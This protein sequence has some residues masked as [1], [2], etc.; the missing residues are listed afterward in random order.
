MD[1]RL[2]FLV[3]QTERYGE[4]LQNADGDNG[5]AG[6][7]VNVNAGGVVGVVERKMTI[8]EALSNSSLGR[9]R[10]NSSTIDY[11]R[12]DKDVSYN[13]SEF[14]GE[15]IIT[16][17][18]DDLSTSCVDEE[19]IDDYY[20]PTEEEL[21]NEAQ[22]EQM[23]YTAL[24]QSFKETS[25]R[26]EVAEEIQKLVQEQDMDLESLIGRLMEEGQA[27]EE[28][29]PAAAAEE[30]KKPLIEVI[31]ETTHAKEDA[32]N[33]SSG[34]DIRNI[35]KRR[36]CF[37]P[38][39]EERTIEPYTD[40]GATALNDGKEEAVVNNATQHKNNLAILN[41]DDHEEEDE[42][43]LK[44]EEL[45][46]ETTIDAEEKLGRD[47]S[48]QEE[49]DLLKQE[50]DMSIEELRAMYA[51]MEE[52]NEGASTS[53]DGNDDVPVAA[54]EYENTSKPAAALS[55]LDE[56][57]QD[58]KDEFH[59]ETEEIDDETTIEV[60][61]KLG[62]D[63][64]YQDEI[65][66]LKM[67]G[68]MSIEE[69]RAMYANM[70]EG[71]NENG[72]DNDD[73]NDNNAPEN[74]HDGNVT[75]LNE[76]A[77]ST[78][79]LDENDEEEKDEF[80]LE[81]EELDDETTIEAEEKLGRDMSYQE[82]IDLL[83][84]EN[85]MSADEL[86]AMYANMDKD[87]SSGDGHDEEG[88]K[89]Q[90]GNDTADS[91]LALL[92][93]DDQEE[94]DEFHLEKEELDDETTIEAE[95]KLGRDMSYQE[96]I[97]LLKQENEMSVE[98]LRAMY[99]NM[100]EG[101]T[102]SEGEESNNQ[103]GDDAEAARMLNSEEAGM[104]LSPRAS[105]KRKHSSA[106]SESDADDDVKTT[107]KAKMDTDEGITEIESLAASDTKAR[108]TMLTRPFLLAS[109][110]KLRAYQHVGLNWL[111]SIQSRRL[112][113]ILADEMGLGKTLQTISMLA[114]L[115]S[116]KGIWGP[117]LIIVP[118]SCLVNWEVE[119]KRFAPGLKVMCYY[120]NAKRRKELRTGWTKPNVHHV[121]ITSYQLAVQDAFAF[122]R[123]KWYYLILDEAHNIKNFESQ[124]WQTLIGF[125]TQRRLLLTGTPLQNNL[126][127]LWSLLHF[128]MPHVFTDRKQFSYWFSN[129]M[130]SIIEGN[131]KRNDDLI[132][133]LHGIIRPFVLRRLKK[134]VETQLP[135]KFEHIVKCQ[136][137]RRQLFLYEEFMARSSTRK[138]MSGG[139]FMGMMSVLMQLRKVCNHPDLFEPRSVTTPF[140]MEPISMSTAAC[141][142]NAVE[143]ESAL[144]RLSPFLRLPLW[145]MG[146]GTPSFQKSTSVD[147]I[148]A[149]QLSD[150]KTTASTI[151]H[152]V[153]NDDLTEPMPHPEMNDGL[154]SLLSRIRAAEKHDRV[155]RAQFISEVNTQR[156]ETLTFPYSDRL[157]QAV[158]LDSSS[159]CDLPLRDELTASQIAATPIELLAMR[160]SQ[161]ERAEDLNEIADK[162][163]FCVPKA[164][165]RK[166]ALFSGNTN[167]PSSATEGTLL[168]KSSTALENYFTPFKKA[169]SRLTMCFP[170][171]K[172]VQ[173]DAGKLQK[174]ATLLRELKRGGHRVLI[175]TQMSKMLDVLEA[176]LNLNGH[177]YLRLDGA[178]DVERRQRLMDR[179][180]NDPKVFCFILS[181]R[182]G[183]LGINL[184]GADTVVFYD[185][186]WNPAMDA[187]AQDR[188]HRIGQTREVHIYRMVTEH[189]IEENILT[190]AKQ[191]R[192][193]DFLVMDEGKF[194][195]TAP[196]KK[197]AKDAET[198]DDDTFTKGKLQNILGIRAEG[199]ELPKSNTEDPMSKDQLESAM[200]ALEDE[201]DV[202]AMHSAR[203][204]AVE[205]LQEFDESIQ[206]K[207]DENVPDE[208]NGKEKKDKAPK[209]KKNRLS[210]ASID[211]TEIDTP[212]IKQDDASDDEKKMEKE[213]AQWQRKVGM[214]AT[215]IHESLNPLER[216][217]L[218]VK[219]QID[220]YY[221]QYFWAEQQ[222]LAQTTKTNN[223]WNIEEIEQKK[224]EEEQKAFEDG[225]LLATF[226]D[227]ESLPR[228]RQL[229][230]REK[231]RLRS[232]IMRRKLTGQNWNTKIE[233]RTGNSFWYNTDTGEAL[234]EK[235]QVL[236]ML[237]AEE[238]A[239]AEGWAALPSSSLVKI[240]E[241]LIPYPE[242][243]T[244]AATCRR[245]R[246]VANDISFVLHVWP[247]E[248]GA[249]IM[250]KS[251]LGKNHFRTIS[252]AMQ[253]ALP[254]DT[255]EL[256]DGHYFINDPGLVV[257][258]PV[259]FVGDENEP[260]HVILELSGEIVWKS[261]GGWMEGI[262]IRRPRIATGVTPSNEIL[263][264]EHGGCLDMFHCAF[265]NRGSIGNCISVRGDAGGR[266]EKAIINGGS[267][268]KSGLMIETNGKVELIDAII[269]D[270]DGVGITRQD[271]AILAL[272]D[273]TVERNG[274]GPTK[275][276]EN[277]LSTAEP[278]LVTS[279]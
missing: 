49:I 30:K 278:S 23:E 57:D 59:I 268:G 43:H 185:S 127:E 248:L 157:R 254:G 18:H 171:K 253:A 66:L 180:N 214:D 206:D 12:M 17:A 244:C 67:E 26:E 199:D 203:Q 90:V 58:E 53:S 170:D 21:A 272:S 134:D 24:L 174:L 133:R 150:I 229:Y 113:G 102:N 13:E 62:R 212:K 114:Y 116:Y 40:N 177:T 273:C 8:E 93:E 192:N 141:V 108:E 2:V 37:A 131:A 217:G 161:E 130:D 100:E 275:E 219:E 79:A 147:T 70:H 64:S 129:P 139:N 20:E 178:T 69:L 159:C 213:F 128:L 16:T 11:S 142:V 75:T 124:R 83:K 74:N 15:S 44:N 235:P 216:Y 195:S 187:Q 81:K 4:R 19:I 271:G 156:C 163:L 166:P 137:S 224:A 78:E 91:P 48:Y 36:V 87:L 197:E 164:G 218:Y 222:R 265:D 105:S 210:N 123:K 239:R 233:E 32:G 22:N 55:P 240:L 176:F 279:H 1:K 104:E 277:I 232:E 183:G 154:V 252:D 215:T 77:L 115:A 143:S 247:V 152:N 145:T 148:L 201:D 76:A 198:E 119:F 179:F 167:S 29:G 135:G 182:S 103:D 259:K 3:R 242:R 136:L 71:G 28:E 117:H 6:A 52:D 155:S 85:E 220:P 35:K 112:N 266:W 89:S 110:V 86:R 151:V 250:D 98:E 267:S 184:T 122:K 255:I 118:T 132:N 228:Q 270:N 236:K 223:E 94:K 158:S 10:A 258:K 269:C 25:S 126:M 106:S 221:S 144:E 262:T 54:D 68:E 249:L 14:Y 73:D 231:A 84:Q 61:E 234:W 140:V 99:S 125:N 95:E 257:N 92:D 226:P 101:P 51:T 46:D 138:A 149:G 274:L 97:D 172:L 241:F 5:A 263:R 31:D 256:G 196:D 50:S 188:A 181:T 227:P 190:K 169:K 120:G 238:V 162:F 65:D 191:K 7:D 189:S 175:F 209:L 33:G 153:T 260:A 160:K 208:I 173:F 38:S 243:T 205:A 109:W 207:Q 245:W 261:R 47:M 39:H 194:H 211:S 168:A 27:V 200:T 88:S 9:R 165:T 225:D 63:M 264:I 60:E 186:D 45:D 107:K 121:V 276:E 246:V 82:E 193:L 251:K 80:H 204:E 42:F 111:V 202:K 146:R 72:S 56:D 96:E 34:D 237:E 41:E 230:I